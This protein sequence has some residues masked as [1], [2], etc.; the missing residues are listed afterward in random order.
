M[1][2]S[3]LTIMLRFSGIPRASEEQPDLECLVRTGRGAVRRVEWSE[4]RGLLEKSISE[5]W[6]LV[7]PNMWRAM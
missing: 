6:K 5:R 3:G 4:K 1:K 7:A 2:R